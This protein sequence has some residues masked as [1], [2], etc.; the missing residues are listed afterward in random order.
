VPRRMRA[1]RVECVLLQPDPQQSERVAARG[2]LP[3]LHCRH[4]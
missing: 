2:G 1:P 3:V 4:G